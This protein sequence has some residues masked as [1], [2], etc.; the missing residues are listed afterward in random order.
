MSRPAAAS[1]GD[2]G[3]AAR[4]MAM[5]ASLRKLIRLLLGLAIAAVI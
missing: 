4:S 1:L 2:A 3:A 5:P